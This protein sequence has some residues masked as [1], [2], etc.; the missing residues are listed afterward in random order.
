VGGPYRIK[1]AA[2]PLYYEAKKMKRLLIPALAMLIVVAAVVLFDPAA[3]PSVRAATTEIVPH[4]GMWPHMSVPI[5]VKHAAV[6]T[7]VCGNVEDEIATVA[8]QTKTS[9]VMAYTTGE[10]TILNW[11]STAD[12][13]VGTTNGWLLIADT[14]PTAF[15]GFVFGQ[16]TGASIVLRVA[17]RSVTSA[18]VT[19]VEFQEALTP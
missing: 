19:I 16:S 3:P 5:P 18:T 9:V 11:W 17:S 13:D 10:N 4:T 2:H 7:V 1:A 15:E 14:A 8:M 6:T 12:A